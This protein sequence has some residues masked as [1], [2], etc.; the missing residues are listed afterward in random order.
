MTTLGERIGQLC[1]ERELKERCDEDNKYAR[2]LRKLVTSDVTADEIFD[3]IEHRP[4]ECTHLPV[5]KHF[6]DEDRNINHIAE[7]YLSPLGCDDPRWK[8]VYVRWRNNSIC[9]RLK[10]SL[11]EPQYPKSDLRAPNTS[12]AVMA[13]RTVDYDKGLDYFPTPPNVTQALLRRLAHDAFASWCPLDQQTFKEPAAGGGHMVD[14]LEKNLEKLIASDIKD[15]GKGYAVADYLNGEPHRDSVDWV[16][17]NPPFKH[18]VKF[19]LKGLEEARV[20]VATFCLIGV[21]R[22]QG[23]VRLMV[24]PCGTYQHLCLLRASPDPSGTSRDQRRCRFGDRLCVVRV[25]VQLE[26]SI[27]AH[28]C[29][30]YRPVKT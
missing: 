29:T 5:G 9:L 14:V 12:T 2:A 17:T 24:Q 18:A 3:F 11:D 4:V 23:S 7:R 26:R 27:T 21:S 19:I 28:R 8:C 15:Y 10:T 1:K 30:G 22:I 16:V 13:R 25:G 20:G 6:K